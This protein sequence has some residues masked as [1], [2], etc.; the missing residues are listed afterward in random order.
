MGGG[1]G[2]QG[3]GGGC[4]EAVGVVG[5]GRQ[6]TGGEWGQVGWALGGPGGLGLCVSKRP[7]V[8]G[9][10]GRGRAELGGEMCGPPSGRAAGAADGQAGV[11]PSLTGSPR[12]VGGPRG[13]P[14]LGAP[15]R[16][17]PGSGGGGSAP[18][19]HGQGSH[20][21][22]RAGRPGPPLLGG[23]CPRAAGPH[24][25]PWQRA[26]ALGLLSAGTC[27]TARGSGGPGGGGWRPWLRLRQGSFVAPFLGL[28]VRRVCGLC[29]SE[30]TCGVLGAAPEP[31][32]LGWACRGSSCPS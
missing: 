31:G 11:W 7:P 17:Q 25:P 14:V 9:G 32:P 18:P 2:P 20:G 13:G 3:P 8:G 27:H 16:V 4:P 5:R 22:S 21:G 1:E 29:C 26:R 30:G 6:P 24:W 10:D 15:A 28:R 23:P 12:A 19:R